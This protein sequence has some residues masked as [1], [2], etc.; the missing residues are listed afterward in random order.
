MV[1]LGGNDG[2]RVCAEVTT[3]PLGANIAIHP[4]THTFDPK[5]GSGVKFKKWFPQGFPLC[6]A[7]AFGCQIHQLVDGRPPRYVR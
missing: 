7:D 5:V 2:W 6:P 3:P 1:V 4:V